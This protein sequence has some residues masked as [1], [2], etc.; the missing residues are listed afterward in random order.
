MLRDQRLKERGSL[1]IERRAERVLGAGHHH[2]RFDPLREPRLERL[3][4]E[5]ELVHRHRHR[6][7]AEREQ[8]VA[9]R[10][11]GGVFDQDPVARAQVSL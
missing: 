7:E 4:E 9:R 3:R 5:A 8:D 10:G 2:D 1:G 6:H 11:V